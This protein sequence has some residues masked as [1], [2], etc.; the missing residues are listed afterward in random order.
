M[1]LQQTTT[2]VRSRRV[3]T[4]H[5]DVHVVVECVCGE[6]LSCAAP[7]VLRGRWRARVVVGQPLR[8]GMARAKRDML[9]VSA[10]VAAESR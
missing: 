2:I 7:G 10:S 8:M 6:T 9:A 1:V 5:I 3:E 4:L